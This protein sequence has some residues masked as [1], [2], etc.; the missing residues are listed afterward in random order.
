MIKISMVQRGQ[1]GLSCVTGVQRGGRDE[2]FKIRARS[3]I[4]GTWE[5]TNFPSHSPLYADHATGNPSSQ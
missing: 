1:L 3:A 2:I 4:A 5:G